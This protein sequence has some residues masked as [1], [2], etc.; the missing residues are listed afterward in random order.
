L[1]VGE[2]SP[3]IS[4]SAAHRIACGTISDFRLL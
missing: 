4:I 3:G 1:P 2:H